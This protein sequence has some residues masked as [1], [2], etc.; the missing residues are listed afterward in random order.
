MP[1]IEDVINQLGPARYISTLDLTRGYWQ[2]PVSKDSIEKTAFVTS[3]GLYKFKRMPFGL[4]GALATFQRLVN[5]VLRGCQS[6]A[7]VYLDDIVIFSATWGEHLLHL[8]RSSHA[9]Q[10]LV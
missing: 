1:R 10:E 7:L 2:V 3:S 6:F 5:K 4:H 8:N 9:C